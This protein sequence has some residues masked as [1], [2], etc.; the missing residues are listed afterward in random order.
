MTMNEADFQ[1]AL[2]KLVEGGF[3]PDE[4][5]AWWQAHGEAT[6]PFVSPGDFICLKPGTLV[7]G[8][9]AAM[10]RSFAQACKLLDGRSVKFTPCQ[11]LIELFE[12]DVNRR[13]SLTDFAARINPTAER[14]FCGTIPLSVAE[15]LLGEYQS[16]GSPN[17]DD[18]LRGRLAALFRW[19]LHPPKWINEPEWPFDGDIPFVFIEQ[20]ELPSNEVTENLLTTDEVLYLFG[21]R[22]PSD[23]GGYSMDY[24]V[25]SQLRL[26]TA[27]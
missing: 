5:I 9:V 25:I 3:S 15:K 2:K 14:D 21:R 10:H 23:N 1:S 7:N 27:D 11:R 24:R 13:F 20:F 4:W 12:G 22:V 19:V 8:T 18:W 6:R 26:A 17:L 16:S